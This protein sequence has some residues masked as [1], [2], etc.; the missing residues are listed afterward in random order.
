[1]RLSLGLIPETDALLA[2]VE[3]GFR[4]MKQGPMNS[5]EEARETVRRCAS[6]S[7]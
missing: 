7:K 2:A 4:S 1:M 6:G 3:D 5:L